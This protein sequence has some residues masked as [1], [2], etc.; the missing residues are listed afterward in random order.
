MAKTFSAQVADWVAR[1]EEK[2]SLVVKFAAQDLFEDV[3]L[4][5]G[6]GGRMRV[7]TGFLRASARVT[8]D[9]PILQQQDNPTG[10][11][12]KEERGIPIYSIDD[13]AI[14]LVINR[15]KPGQTLFMTFTANYARHREYGV[16][17]RSPDAFVSSHTALWQMY[18]DRAVQKVRNM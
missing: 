10:S 18:C 3:L 11:R 2:L 4:P 17:G 9:N 14:N 16:R 8:L 1:S 6:E 5:V 13:G 15:M 12:P 7:D